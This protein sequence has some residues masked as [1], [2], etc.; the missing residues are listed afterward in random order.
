MIVYQNLY[1]VGP[2]VNPTT[3]RKATFL[4]NKRDD[5]PN[6]AKDRMVVVARSKDEA[7]KKYRTL[8]P[9]GL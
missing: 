6:T 5:I 7:R 1:F 4:V 8:L 2:Y 3:G 9:K